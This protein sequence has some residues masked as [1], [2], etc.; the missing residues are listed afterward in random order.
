LRFGEKCPCGCGYTEEKNWRPRFVAIEQDCIEAENV[1][2]LAAKL[3]PNVLYEEGQW[4]YYMTRTH[5]WIYRMQTSAARADPKL[6]VRRGYKIGKEGGGFSKMMASF[7]RNVAAR[8]HQQKLDDPL[9]L[10]VKTEK[11][12]A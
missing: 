7:S 9:R 2:E 4:T 5:K 6:F 8:K 12:P 10:L 1:P 11:V 3:T